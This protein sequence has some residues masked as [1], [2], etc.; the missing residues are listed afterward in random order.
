[1]AVAI[2]IVMT[3]RDSARYVAQA[4]GSLRAQ[5]FTDWELVFVDDGS[6]DDTLAIARGFD[7]PRI[8]IFASEPI[9]R[10]RALIEAHR[11]TRGA[12]L[13]WLDAD[14][15]LAPTALERTHAALADHDLVYTNHIVVGPTGAVR[16]LGKRCEIPYSPRRLLVDFMTFHFR[17]FTRDVFERAGGISELEIAIDYDLCLRISEHARIAHLAEPLYF[18]R[19]HEAQMS[20][21]GRAAQV[22]ASAVAIRA[23]IARRGWPFEL[24]VEDERFRL[25]RTANPLR[26]TEWLR[27]LAATAFPASVAA[28]RSSDPTVGHW[29]DRGHA[30]GSQPTEI[31]ELLAT[32]ALSVPLG[33]DLPSLLRAVWTGR[34][35]GTLVIHDLAPL[36][37]GTPAEVI[38]NRILFAKTLDH[39]LA[40]GTRIMWAGS[41]SSAE[42]ART[43]ETRA[44]TVVTTSARPTRIA[45]LVVRRSSPGPAP[46]SIVIPIRNRAGAD[47]RNALASLQ[48]QRARPFEVILV[49]HG[50]DPAIDL[51]LREIAITHDATLVVVGE[52]SDP[53][54]KPLALN[55]GIRAT[56]PAVPFV[57]TLD[58]DMI[59]AEDLLENVLAELRT[60]DTLVL[61]E[62][63]DLPATCVVP[64]DVRAHFDDLARQA[65]LR[66]RFG[67]GGLQAVRRSFLFDV[68]GYDEDMVW[69]GSLDTDLVRRAEASGLTVTWLAARMLHQW[70]PRKFRV[71][72]NHTHKRDAQ[73]AWLR[74]Q[75]LMA[76]RA[77]EVARN[78]AGWGA[79][80]VSDP[81]R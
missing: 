7:D 66:G 67:T 41:R 13:G 55:T 29:P 75:E 79:P 14:D 44:T 2:S 68:R 5:T 6:T 20:E 27:A 18:Y 42:L 50:S 57:M 21:R 64:T 31:P 15:W 28:L 17:L 10:R 47:L 9:G 8:R 3:A 58:G 24:V 77:G 51:E 4:I 38:A 53:W 54:N 23:A 48:W 39:A 49:S 12:A 69:W 62:A 59:L 72:D 78:P 32:N 70:H 26:P 63:S 52:P 33:S 35:G 46:I 71:L 1:M 16:G 60:P 56:D 40:R 43:I 34:A 61:C 30:L 25:E 81:P 74:N 11:H 36:L 73:Y 76:E 37:E 80:L 19:V 45:T 22:A 65:T